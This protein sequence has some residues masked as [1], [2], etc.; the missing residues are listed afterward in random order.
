M[1]KG[2]L[3]RIGL[4]FQHIVHLVRPEANANDV[5][6]GLYTKSMPAPDEM[7]NDVAISGRLSFLP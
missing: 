7:L 1:T 5:C 6:I 4:K 3:K 2:E